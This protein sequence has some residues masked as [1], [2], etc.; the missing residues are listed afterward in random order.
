MSRRSPMATTR[1]SERTSASASG[2]AESKVI[3]CP[4]V[5]SVVV[6][7]ASLPFVD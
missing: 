1:P 4:P 2:T 3:T 7:A 6:I 5:M